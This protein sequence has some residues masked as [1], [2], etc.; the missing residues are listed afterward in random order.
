LDKEK[1]ESL[2]RK[3]PDNGVSEF[4]FVLFVCLVL[5][6]GFY[7]LLFWGVGEKDYSKQ[8]RGMI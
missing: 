7:Y 5:M 8:T 6:L 2:N 1:S 3:S 4:V